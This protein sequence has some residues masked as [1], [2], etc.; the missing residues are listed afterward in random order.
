[1]AGNQEIKLDLTAKPVE[2]APWVKALVGEPVQE[3]DPTREFYFNLACG[4]IKAAFA[5]SGAN[6]L[7]KRKSAEDF[8]KADQVLRR[9]QEDHDRKSL[10]EQLAPLVARA[11]EKLSQ[12]HGELLRQALAAFDLSIVTFFLGE[13]FA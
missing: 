2:L 11:C 6:L 10:A 4:D 5:P 12:E 13:A 3:L 7:H 9:F 1:M 8:A